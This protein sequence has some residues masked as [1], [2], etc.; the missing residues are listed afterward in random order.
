MVS[1]LV[2]LKAPPYA[3][4]T[5]WG[6]WP[7]QTLDVEVMTFASGR[8]V[9]VLQESLLWIDPNGAAVRVPSG[10]VC[11]GASIPRFAWILMGGKLSLD[12]L[13]SAI[14]HDYTILVAEGQSSVEWALTSRDA[15]VRFYRGLRADGMGFVRARTA[16][17]TVEWFGP[18]WPR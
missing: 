13:R 4:P 2:T 15:S 17:R 6:W 1:S 5:A 8:R 9:V 3:A 14:V 12:F 11:D 10:F 18:E 16:Y 7:D